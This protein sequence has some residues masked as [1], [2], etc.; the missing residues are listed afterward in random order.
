MT[1]SHQIVLAT[2]YDLSALVELESVCFDIDR[3]SRRSIKRWIQS[4]HAV[5]AL[6]KEGEQLIAYIL[7][8]FH[9]GTRLARL[10]SLAVAPDHRRRGIAT[11]L[12]HFAERA[13]SEEG[14]LFMRLEVSNRNEAAINCYEALGYKQFGFYQEYYEDASDALRYQKCIRMLDKD[15]QL[16]SLSWLSQTTPF[17]CGPTA[18]MMAMAALDPTFKP[19]QKEELRL[20][21]EATT[22]YMTSGHGGCHPMGLALA[23]HHRDFGAEVWL[24]QRGTLFIDGVRQEEKKDI[25]TVVHEDYCQMMKD[26]KLKV[27]YSDI[28][29]EALIK[30]FDQ[31]DIPLILISTYRLDKTKSPH[32]VT[33]S[34]YDEDCIYV[35][36]PA[37]DEDSQT[38]LD[39]QYL[40]ILRADFDMMSC[41]GRSRLR[42][43]V[44]IKNK[45][46]K[47]QGAMVRKS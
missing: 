28:H 11:D 4:D 15:S 20:W 46:C 10:Y 19:S 32:W 29:H 34:G 37:P 44:L 22:I 8:I 6:L 45:K 1:M 2:P 13:A 9:R 14:R 7:V 3:L 16:L 23:A 17:T 12:I 43:A 39:C 40:P 38:A 18:L 24:N 25:M 47:K 41:Y 21:R 5:F 33:M 31:G 26:R 30:A 42:T 35:H 36:D 27:H